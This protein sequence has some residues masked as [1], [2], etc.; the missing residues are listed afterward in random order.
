MSL[1]LTRNY[2]GPIVRVNPEELSIHDPAFYNELYVV[3]GKRRTEGYNHFCK[4]I[5]LDGGLIFFFSL[6][7]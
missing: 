3:E 7:L 2:L 6:N 4:G 1:D 5:D